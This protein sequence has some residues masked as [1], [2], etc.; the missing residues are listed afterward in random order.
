MLTYFW[1]GKRAI[2]LLDIDKTPLYDPM[3]S[4]PQTF[5]DGGCDVVIPIKYA[6]K[7]NC[8]TCIVLASLHCL[9]NPI[10]ATQGLSKVQ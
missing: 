8:M 10:G 9:Y 5:R 1:G 7:L 4:T 6:V 2:A 3:G